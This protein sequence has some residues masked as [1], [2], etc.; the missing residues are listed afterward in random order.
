MD[1]LARA[2]LRDLIRREVKP[3]LISTNPAASLHAY[4]LLYRLSR[5]S[6]EMAT[7]GRNTPLA[8]RRD[9]IVLGYLPGGVS[10]VRALANALYDDSFQQQVIFG[11]DLEGASSGITPDQL[12][13]LRA[14]PIFLLAQSQ[15]NVQTWVEQYRPPPN[16]PPD[17]RLRMVIATAAAATATA[18]TYAAAE[19]ERIIGTLSG[20]RDALLYREVRAQYPSAEAQ[21]KAEQRWQSVGFAAFAATLAILI[22]A[23]L[24]MIQYLAQRRRS[25]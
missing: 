4:N 14:Q 20:L 9:Y 1:D 13:V 12:R 3:I 11:N 21:R 19:P 5:D 16:A 22:G 8:P 2:L 18:Q 10:G 25:Q 6:A 17:S 23:A 7:L 15:E 24:S